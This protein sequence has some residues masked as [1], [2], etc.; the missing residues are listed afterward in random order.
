[1]ALTPLRAWITTTRLGYVPLLVL[2]ALVLGA[3]CCLFDGHADDDVGLDLCFGMLV[4]TIVVAL[5]WRLLQ[6][7]TIATLAPALLRGTAP[8]V[9]EPPPRLFA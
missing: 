2:T 6:S 3:G 5:S 4:M 7:G 9:L 1:M 8:H